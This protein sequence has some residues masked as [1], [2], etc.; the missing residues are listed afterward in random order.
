MS[1]NKD[2]RPASQRL[3][4]V[5]SEGDAASVSVAR[6]RARRNQLTPLD[7]NQLEGQQASANPTPQQTVEQVQQEGEENVPV[8]AGILSASLS[9]KRLMEL[10]RVK[11]FP[12]FRLI[13]GGQSKYYTPAINFFEPERTEFEER[14]ADGLKFKCKLCP[15]VL[16]VKIG[17]FSNLN[18]HLDKHE[19]SRQW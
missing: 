18:Q 16:I 2:K 19:E 8:A 5:V 7:L 4:V 15:G 13:L 10:A 12:K 17:K 6:A 11:Q 14:P 9:V 1:K 3:T